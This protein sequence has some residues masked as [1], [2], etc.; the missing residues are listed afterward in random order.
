MSLSTFPSPTVLH[1]GRTLVFCLC[2]TLA[3]SASAYADVIVMKDGSRIEGEILS[4]SGGVFRVR[5]SE[6]AVVEIPALQIKDIERKLTKRQELAN[7]REKI[8]AG[9]AESLF[10]L[11]QWAKKSFLNA[12][13][14]ALFEE[15]LLADPDHAA[16]RAAL[17]FVRVDDR[18]VPEAEFYQSKGF[19]RFKGKWVPKEFADESKTRER[20][21]AE[22]WEVIKILRRGDKQY[23]EAEQKLLALEPLNL[24]APILLSRLDERKLA[25]RKLLIQALARCDYEPAALELLEIAFDDEEFEVAA[26]AGKAIWSQANRG[27]VVEAKTRLVQNLFHRHEKTRLRA[28]GLLEAIK[29][30]ETIP[31][32]IE[33]LYLERIKRVTEVDESYGISRAGPMGRGVYGQYN[34]P[35]AAGAGVVRLREVDKLTF[36]FNPIARRALQ[37]MSGRGYDYSKADWYKWWLSQKPADP[38]PGPRRNPEDPASPASPPINPAPSPPT[39]PTDPEGAPPMVPRPGDEPTPPA[40]GS[41]EPIE[42]K[43]ATPQDGQDAP[44][45]PAETPAK[46]E[47]PAMPEKKESSGE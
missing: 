34:L 40:P 39:A 4:E 43:P 36:V 15:A 41:P 28:A 46:P 8:E 21:E 10:E 38:A 1:H 47:E 31:Y 42:P 37:A 2:L 17:G 30:R 13:S 32:L 44:K 35:S 25:L 18:W 20:L 29:D 6:F 7:R 12:E 27:R 16:A 3:L 19:V 45:P 24:L 22:V 11:A 14:R 26:I 33:A 9:D 5:V 23:L